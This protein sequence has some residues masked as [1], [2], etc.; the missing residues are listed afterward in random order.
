MNKY[1]LRFAL[2]FFLL[3]VLLFCAWLVH[4]YFT[5]AMLPTYQD[6]TPEIEARMKTHVP[7]SQGLFF[8]W[9]FC[10]FASTIFG[11]LAFV[12]RKKSSGRD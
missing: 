6:P 10:F 8:A 12:M 5:G 2:G 3:F 1:L 11:F 9:F 7:I 4:D